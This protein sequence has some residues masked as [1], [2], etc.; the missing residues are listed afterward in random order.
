MPQFPHW[1]TGTSISIPYGCC[2][3][4]T[5]Q[6]NQGDSASSAFREDSLPFHELLFL[7]YLSSHKSAISM[8]TI[9]GVAMLI[10]SREA[11]VVRSLMHIVH[12]YL[13]MLLPII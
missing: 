1:K 2:K 10:L 3:D 8:H 13:V 7:K 11:G 12:V 9:N 5:A 4:E 6:S